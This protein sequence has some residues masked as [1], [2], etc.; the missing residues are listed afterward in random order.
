MSARQVLPLAAV[1][2]RQQRDTG[3]SCESMWGHETWKGGRDSQEQILRSPFCAPF[4]SEAAAAELEHVGMWW[5]Q[6]RGGGGESEAAAA[7][8]R[9]RR[10]ERGGSEGER[11]RAVAARVG[12]ASGGERAAA[13]TCGRA[14][15]AR[16]MPSRCGGGDGI[17]WRMMSCRSPKLAAVGGG[18]GS[19]SPGSSPFESTLAHS[20]SAARTGR[21]HREPVA[22]RGGVRAA[23]KRCVG[24]NVLQTQGAIIRA[25]ASA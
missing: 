6:G 8:A 9:R 23:G 3:P 13:R 7:R 18:G 17:M 2:K 5:R 19:S 25:L 21:L 16:P 11:R 22:A 24:W 20:W 15:V 14:T 10:R 1:A 12:R 4:R